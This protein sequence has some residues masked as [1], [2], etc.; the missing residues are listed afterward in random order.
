MDFVAQHVGRGGVEAVPP[1][2][3][4]YGFALCLVDGPEQAGQQSR[5]AVMGE[6]LPFLIVKILKNIRE[7]PGGLLAYFPPN[8]RLLAKP[9]HRCIQIFQ[10]ALRNLNP[11]S[12]C[13]QAVL[14]VLVVL[15]PAVIVVY[16]LAHVLRIFGRCQAAFDEVFKLRFVHYAQPKRSDKGPERFLRV[17]LPVVCFYFHLRFDFPV[18]D[19]PVHIDRIRSKIIGVKAFSTSFGV[20]LAMKCVNWP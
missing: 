1:G 4:I 3:H 11:D 10:V 7:K 2:L 17:G 12:L 6:F 19:T 5:R 16:P 15:S 18:N 8:V 14:F 13:G 9:Y 20:T